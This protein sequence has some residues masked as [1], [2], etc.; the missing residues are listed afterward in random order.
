VLERLS[1]GVGFAHYPLDETAVLIGSGLESNDLV[2]SLDAELGHRLAWSAGG[3]AGWL[4]DGNHRTSGFIAL[5]HSLPHGS[6]GVL[7][8]ALTYERAGA[9]YFSPDRF[10]LVEARTTLARSR[11]A[12]TG[13]VSAGLGAQ[14][15]GAR[16]SSQLAWRATGELQFGWA[17]INRIVA[18]IG[19]SNSAA[20]STTGAYRHLAAAVALR[21]G[22]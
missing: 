20:S 22:I 7:G 11:R 9:G 13:R 12:W 5:M 1:A 6:V 3:G 4:S 10:A 18:S 14:Q 21:I 15:V 16:A 19:A 17:T 8:R 2:G